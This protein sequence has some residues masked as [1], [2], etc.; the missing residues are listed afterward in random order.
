M[1]LDKYGNEIWVIPTKDKFWRL[2][3]GDLHRENDL[4]AVEC[5][6]GDK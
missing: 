3:N 4:Q 5:E 2:P 6:N 1:T